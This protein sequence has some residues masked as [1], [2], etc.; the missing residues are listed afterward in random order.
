L[1]RL[2]A[3][4]DANRIPLAEAAIE[5]YWAATALRAR[6]SGLLHIQQILHEQR[7]TASPNSRDL[8]ATADAYIEQKLVT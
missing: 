3:A 8:A 6:K 1:R 7:D 5:E 4:G 2:V